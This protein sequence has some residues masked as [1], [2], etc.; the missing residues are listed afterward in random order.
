MN[1]LGRASG[2]VPIIHNCLYKNSIWKR[3]KKRNAPWLAPANATDRFQ[4]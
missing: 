4:Y 1:P 3:N 2:S